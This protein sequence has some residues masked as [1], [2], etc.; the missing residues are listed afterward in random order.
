VRLTLALAVTTLA[1]AG[2]GEPRTLAVRDAFVRL[3]AVEGR[4]AAAYFTLDGGATD[5]TLV[6]VAT[7][8]AIRVELHESM[9]ASG[10]MMTMDAVRAVPVKAGATVAFAP[11]GKHAM[12]FDVN[13]RIT[14]GTKVPLT[15]AFADGTRVRADAHVIAAGDPAPR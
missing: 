13:P 14:P 6:S 8:A 1:L 9:A 11:G 3:A 7:D 2:C 4:P 5:A 12:L 15:F 10:G